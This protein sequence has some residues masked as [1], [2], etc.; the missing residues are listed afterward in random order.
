MHQADPRRLG[1]LFGADAILYI[2]IENWEAKYLIISTTVTV[3]FTY[4][5]KDASSGEEIWRHHEVMQY[6]PQNQN[7]G[8]LIG[9]IIVAV[10][11]AAVTK[12]IPNYIP[13]ARQANTKAITA[14]NQGIPA[15]PHH[16][17]YKQDVDDY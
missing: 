16:P 3:A 2:N 4:V 11:N 8:N 15:G 9:N 17:N 6:T 14:P 10:I 13:L 12:A 1:E 5:L 7:T